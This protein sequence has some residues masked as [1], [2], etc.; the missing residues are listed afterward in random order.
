MR[1]FEMDQEGAEFKEW[2]M[3]I[4]QMGGI[5]S[6]YPQ[7]AAELSF[8]TVKDYDDWIAR[9]HALPTAFAQVTENMSIGMED[10]RVP[11]KYLLGKGA[12]PGEG[13]GQPEARRLAAGPA[14]QRSFPHPFPPPSRSASRPRC[15]T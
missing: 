9:L 11:P 1:E 6:D 4:N 12:R 13:A 14:P 3:P 10:G 15:S 5:Y 7:L 8:T 2:E